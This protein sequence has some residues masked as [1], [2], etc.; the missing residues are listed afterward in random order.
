MNLPIFI[1]FCIVV[2]AYLSGYFSFEK[3]HEFNMDISG[4]MSH[5]EYLTQHISKSKNYNKIPDKFHSY[6][7]SVI[8]RKVEQMVQVEYHFP[9]VNNHKHKIELS[10]DPESTSRQ[11]DLYGLPSHAVVKS[12]DGDS[13]KLNSSLGTEVLENTLKSGAWY[14]HQNGDFGVD[15]PKLAKSSQEFSKEIADS[16]SNSLISKGLDSYFNR[17]QAALNFVQFIPYGLPEF[18]TRDWYYHGLSLPQESFVIGYAD[19]DSKSLFMASILSN[20][21]PAENFIMVTCMVKS[22]DDRRSGGHMMI[23]VSDL[24][25]KGYSVEF[26][27]KSYVLIE[28]TVPSQMGQEYWAE[29]VIMDKYRLV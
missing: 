5:I 4:N 13:M 17:V 12:A 27:G 9:L 8:T 11:V 3:Q 22:K 1:L 26:K 28:T 20:L 15:Y 18:D 2:V 7:K 24:G 6:D 29:I 25:I 21:V 10:M 23:G 19:C 14:L 16:I